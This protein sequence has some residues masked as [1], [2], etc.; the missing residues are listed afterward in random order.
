ML[1]YPMDGWM[2]YGC[3]HHYC[4]LGKTAKQLEDH[5][6]ELYLGL[7]GY[8]LPQ[9]YL[10]INGDL[11]ECV[12]AA[13]PAPLLQDDVLCTDGEE[14]EEEGPHRIPV[15]PGYSLGES[16]VRDGGESLIRL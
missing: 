1:P 15:R 11:Q 9:H 3:A 16:V 13:A 12:A 4:L 5:Y 6:W 14:E 2:G 7:H 8:C 10:D